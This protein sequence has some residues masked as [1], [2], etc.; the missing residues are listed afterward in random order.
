MLR[1]LGASEFDPVIHN[2]HHLNW[3]HWSRA[4]VMFIR[5][6]AVLGERMKIH[7][8]SELDHYEKTSHSFSVS[9]R[10]RFLCLS[11]NNDIGVPLR[12]QLWY[13]I[14]VLVGVSFNNR[15]LWLVA[16]HQLIS[17]NSQ[18]G[19][20]EIKLGQYSQ[21]V[22]ILTLEFKIWPNYWRSCLLKWK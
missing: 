11:R 6:E 15:A 9:L 7:G 1:R 5:K 2:A 21:R 12:N 4:V 22:V 3:S 14:T 20:P 16:L 19:D 13:N 18:Y 10:N 8:C 17:C